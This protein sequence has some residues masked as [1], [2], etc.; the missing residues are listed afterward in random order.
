MR[1]LY[2]L[3]IHIDTIGGSQKSTRTI[4]H[5]MLKQHYEVGILMLDNHLS[6]STMDSVCKTYFFKENDSMHSYAYKLYRCKGI[7]DCIKN[8]HPDIV[9]AQNPG[10]GML[11]GFMKKYQ[12]IPKSIKCVFT[13]RDYFTAYQP[14]VRFLFQVL[15]RNYDAIVTTTKRNQEEWKIY[16]RTKRITCIKNVLEDDWFEYDANVETKLKRDYQVE[17]QFNIGFSGRYVEYKKWN[18]VYE[19]CDQLK[20]LNEICFTVAIT[21]E[22]GSRKEMMRYLDNLK[23]NL[24]KKLKII[25]D[26]QEDKMKEFYY[27]LDAF[28]LTSQRESFGR[29]VIE[30]MT[31]N[32]L[33]FGTN[34]GGVPEVIGNHEF[35]FEVEDSQQI[36]SL[37]KKFIENKEN[38]EIAKR[39]FRE[40]AA[41]NFKAQIL[42]RKHVKLYKTLLDMES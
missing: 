5:C 35:L 29:T 3:D 6:S 40:Y 22:P 33:V 28:V 11:L 19:I 27:I 21:C 20:N 9:H 31:K 34:S 41:L 17:H 1:I 13:D 2:L 10:S 23:R 14:K 16:T 12:L 30:A 4:I 7:K 42:E 8:F 32:N 36:C 38:A 24:G 25:T 26:A 15:G 39:A 37:L 18:T